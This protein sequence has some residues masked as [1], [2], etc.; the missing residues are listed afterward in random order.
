[1]YVVDCQSLIHIQTTKKQSLWQYAYDGGIIKTS[2]G[3]AFSFNISTEVF[4]K[5]VTK[6]KHKNWI[7]NF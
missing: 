7:R 1:M 2:A 4:S 5:P 3:I 6:Y